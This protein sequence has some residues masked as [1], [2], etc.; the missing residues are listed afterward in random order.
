MMDRQRMRCG[1][2]RTGDDLGALE[3]LVGMQVARRQGEEQ[4]HGDEEQVGAAP[5]VGE[6]ESP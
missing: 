6:L 1:R 3:V 2:Q 4:A 5:H